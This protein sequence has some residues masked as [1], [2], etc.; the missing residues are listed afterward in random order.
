MPSSAELKAAAKRLECEPGV[1][2]AIESNETKILTGF[3]SS[4]RP[5]IL[6]EP[7]KFH[8]RTKRKFDRDYPQI[9][10]RSSKVIY[11]SFSS[12]YSKLEIAYMLAPVAALESTSWGAFQIMG[13][14]YSAAGYSSAR[15]M[16]VS[17]TASVGNQLSGFVSFVLAD[18]TLHKYVKTKTR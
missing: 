2:Y 6:F 4:G 11:G 16:V 17:M 15:E 13:F 9:S 8:T 1:I 14:N 7:H 10:V 3:D 12:Q 18:L 5:T